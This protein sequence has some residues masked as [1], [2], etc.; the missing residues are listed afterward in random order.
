MQ[1]AEID[2]GVEALPA[3]DG[4][5]EK[6]IRFRNRLEAEFAGRILGLENETVR[7]RGSLSGRYR[8]ET[9]GKAQV[10]GGLMAASAQRREFYLATRNV[11][12]VAQLGAVT[13]N[14]WVDDPLDFPL[15]N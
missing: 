15:Q 14:P 2:Q 11:R 12:D 1:L 8:R 10:V 6:Y 4:R 13:F 5:R 3:G 9:G 7:L